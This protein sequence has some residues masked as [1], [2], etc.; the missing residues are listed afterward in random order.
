V[1]W[2][3]D[4]T[5][6]WAKGWVGWQGFDRFFS[7]LVRWTFPGEE[8]GGIEAEFVTEGDASRLRVTSVESDGTPRDFYE[9]AV[10]VVDPELGQ[11]VVS[12][13]QVGPGVYEAP[14]GT[15]KP[16]AYAM[17]VVQKR[18][19]LADLGRTLGLVAP[20]PAEYR[21][22]G[23]DEP[24]LTTLRSATGGRAIETAAEVWTHDLR[25][26]AFATDLWPL[27]L[28]LALLLFPIDV[29]IRRVSI[30]RREVAAGRAWFG[31]RVLGRGRAARPE[32]VGGML[33]AKERAAGSR[34]RAALVRPATAAP[35]A[36]P[37][38]EPTTAPTATIEPPSANVSAPSPAPD[39]P[40]QPT[41]SEP[42]PV[43]S[44]EPDTLARL[45]EAKK[46]AQ[47]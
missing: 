43:S 17:R 38:T 40:K 21:L 31:S 15:L 23:V 14:M 13:E 2:T 28:V 18:A 33:A 35:D 32:V 42:P 47:R 6:R 3:S 8:T 10:T 12:L 7:Q 9:T 1:A 36:L 45:R 34:S 16:G 44:A 5:G 11:Q 39:Q 46:R 27:L 37:P 22:L 19:G 29:A 41:P 25:S 30:S 20:S 26:T 24:L 4:A